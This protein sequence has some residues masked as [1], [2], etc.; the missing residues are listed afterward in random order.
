[1]N[2]HNIVLS[3]GNTTNSVIDNAGITIEGGSG[4]DAKLNYSL[5]GGSSP[6]WEFKIGD[7]FENLKVATLIGDVSATTISVDGTSGQIQQQG[8]STNNIKLSTASNG[9]PQQIFSTDTSLFVSAS[10]VSYTHLTLP[11][12]CSV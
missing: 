7:S 3:S 2:D 11:T 1:M 6:Q 9:T 10:A 4:D 5:S 8:A 12:I